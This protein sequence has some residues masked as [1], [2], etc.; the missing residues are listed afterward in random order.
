VG[1]LL[2]EVCDE[3]LQILFAGAQR[4]QIQR[5]GASDLGLFPRLRGVPGAP[6]LG[7]TA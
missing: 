3:V 7:F 2:L 5:G 4:S 1:D 6:G